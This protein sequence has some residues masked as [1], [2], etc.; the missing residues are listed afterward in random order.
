MVSRKSSPLSL[1]LDED[2]LAKL[3]ARA[4]GLEMSAGALIRSIV[5]DNLNS[6]VEAQLDGILAEI[7][8]GQK[9]TALL[10]ADLNQVNANVR[11]ALA[12]L[13]C[14]QTGDEQGAA[15]HGRRSRAGSRNRGLK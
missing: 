11:A 13:L 9:E 3:E 1:R 5:T 12:A 10:R 15:R 14:V 2:D 7:A 6:T 4:A 8:S